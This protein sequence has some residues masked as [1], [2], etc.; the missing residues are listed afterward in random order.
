MYVS[1][2]SL[3]AFNLKPKRGRQQ[4]KNL[5]SEVWGSYHGDYEDSS[6]R[7]VNILESDRGF[8]TFRKNV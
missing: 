1:L 4:R 5:V 7:N 2:E 6:L 8:P 3:K